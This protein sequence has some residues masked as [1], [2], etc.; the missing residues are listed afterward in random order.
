[1]EIVTH[2]FLPEE[3]WVLLPCWAAAFALLAAPDWALAAKPP[4][5]M[6]LPPWACEMVRG[7]CAHMCH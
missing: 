6:S 3:P 7:S 2:H 4:E 1:M 5:D